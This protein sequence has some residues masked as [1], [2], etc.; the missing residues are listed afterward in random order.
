MVN[1][2]YIYIYMSSTKRGVLR[3]FFVVVGGGGMTSQSRD[4]CVGGGGGGAKNISVD[5]LG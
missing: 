1:M 5:K 2:L 4:P 3:H